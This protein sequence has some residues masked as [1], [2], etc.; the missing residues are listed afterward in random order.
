M[1]RVHLTI[2]GK[3]QGVFFRQ[4]TKEKAKEFRLTGW[5]ANESDG[6][7]SVI[8]EGEENRVNSLIE[9]CRSGP[10]RSIVDKVIVKK[11]HI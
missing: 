2:V 7:V 4:H 9:W 3:V 1:I 10:S 11:N 5:V 8:I 6:T